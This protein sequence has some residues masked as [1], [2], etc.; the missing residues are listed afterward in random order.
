MCSY[1]KSIG[2]TAAIMLA[3][4]LMIA[5]CESASSGNTAGDDR[6]TPV[7][8]AQ[9]GE[10]G[11]TCEKCKVTWT[12]VPDTGGKGRVVAYKTRR[13]H[14]CPDCRSAVNNFFTTGKMEHTCKTCGDD[15][16][17]ICEA[18]AR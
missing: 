14:E 15:A 13:S 6:G 18:H 2:A 12:K 9:G 11:V 16:L 8:A 7:M 17:Q 5:G 10:Q 4:T 1:V 3:A